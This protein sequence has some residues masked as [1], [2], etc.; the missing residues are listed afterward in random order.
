MPTVRE[1]LNFL[2]TL[3]PMETKMS[4]D[5]VGLLAG[6]RDKAVTKVLAAL[7]ITDDVISEA[8]K[9]GA[10]LIVAHH[11]LIFTPLKHVTDED[12]EGRRV[13]RLIRSQIA[14]ICMHTNLDLS[15]G[16]VNDALAQRLGLCNAEILHMEGK[17]PD[18]EVY[19][20]GRIGT[21]REALPME[22]FC[23]RVKKEL[24]CGGLRCFDA[25]RPVFRVGVGGGACG[26][27]LEEAAARGCDT[28]L[29]AD[30]KY[31]VFLEAAA[32]GINL[33][34]AGHY[35]TEDTVIPVLVQR[36][37][38]KYPELTVVKSARHREVIRY[39]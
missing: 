29:T 10:E 24:G 15:N 5:N 35:P 23:R 32:I 17:G 30:V 7:D 4:F 27:L 31:N 14:A 1:I 22:D 18:G 2:D 21:L 11:P 34:D 33:A 37:R 36:I 6:E 9:M 28:Y 16:G 19:G 8:E 25:G 26:D 20:L 3:A 38:G 39:L 13:I 12:A